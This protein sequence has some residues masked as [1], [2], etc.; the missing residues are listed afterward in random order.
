M[1]SGQL[2]CKKCEEPLF[3]ASDIY[4][5]NNTKLGKHQCHMVFVRGLDW[6]KKQT[7]KIS[8]D[9]TCFNCQLK[10][11][12]YNLKEIKCS[13]CGDCQSPGFLISRTNLTGTE[14]AST[15]QVTNQINQTMEMEK[16]RNNSMNKKVTQVPL[17]NYSS[18]NLTSNQ[19]RKPTKGFV[20]PHEKNSSLISQIALD[21]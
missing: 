15:S 20:S 18:S 21:H 2:K 6:I 5:G 7:T 11:G 17:T 9:L 4:P 19:T 13:L 3:S 10:I 1:R 14:H 12:K 8:G 16:I